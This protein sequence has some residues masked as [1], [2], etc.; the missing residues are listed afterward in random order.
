RRVLFRSVEDVAADLPV[1]GLVGV[2][3]AQDVLGVLEVVVVHLDLRA[4]TGVDARVP[5]AGEVV[6]VGVGRA[7]AKER[8]TG[9]EVLVQVV[10]EGD[11]GV[12]RVAVAGADQAA[13]VGAAQDAV[14]QG[15]ILGVV[16]HVEQRVVAVALTARG[17]QRHVVDPDVADVLLHADGV[18]AVGGGRA[19]LLDVLDGHVLDDDVAGLPDVD[20]DL[21]E[22]GAAADADDR[23]VADLLELDHV[24]GRVAAA[25]DLAGVAVVDGA[26]HLDD[27]RRV[28][29]G[30]AAQGLVDLGARA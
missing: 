22:D 21:V 3:G 24:V 30:P 25:G 14:G 28:V 29:V 19:R 10:V 15:H 7:G 2:E 11:E 8:R 5:D 9:L 18:A 20:A 1:A 13:A 17:L 26:G 12:V 16:L 27:D 6:V 4:E 23:D